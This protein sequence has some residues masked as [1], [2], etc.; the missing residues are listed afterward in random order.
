MRVRL[1][2][3]L[4]AVFTAGVA[5]CLLTSDFDGI[6]GVRPASDA[7]AEAADA[8]PDAA[9]PCNDA[10]L[11]CSHFDHESGA[12]PVPG[13]NHE[14][15]DSGTL[16][17]DSTTAVSPPSAVHM[18]VAG[19]AEVGAYLYRQVF[20]GPFTRISIEVDVRMGACPARP[21]SLTLL[22]LEPS[23]RASFGL[24]VLSSGVHA[25]GSSISGTPT[26]FPLETQLPTDAWAHVVYR[27]LVKDAATAHLE[28]TVDGKK[29]IDTDAPSAP[30]RQ[31]ALLNLGVL[32]SSAPGGCEVLYDNFVLDRE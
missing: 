14:I 2:A 12:L 19:S 15:L 25:L 28:L 31:T 26:F 24:V 20:L 4:A 3:C 32:G 17:V 5:G 11:V 23:T 9:S 6:V 29:G 13:W 1:G 27:I 8:G 16:N 22:Y 7:A 21:S 18:R 10:H 30:M